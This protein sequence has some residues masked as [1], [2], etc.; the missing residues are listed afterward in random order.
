MSEFSPSGSFR[1]FR[2]LV[3]TPGLTSEYP[4]CSVCVCVCVYTQIHPHTLPPASKNRQYTDNTPISP[5][6]KNNPLHQA[7][8]I[9]CRLA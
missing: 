2:C 5:F 4:M 3:P 8:S 9:L 6:T 1:P 7:T